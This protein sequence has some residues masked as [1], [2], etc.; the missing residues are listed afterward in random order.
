MPDTTAPD[1]TTPTRVQRLPA[2]A[3]NE[4]REMQEEIRKLQDT[5][6]LVEAENQRLRNVIAEHA[7]NGGPADTYLVNE[8]TAAE[9]PLGIGPEIRFNSVFSVHYEADVDL[10]IVETD[11]DMC[12]LPTD[13]GRIIEMGIRK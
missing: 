1:I 11:Q 10:L 2:W 4:R 3:R 13:F 9:L 8:D 6:K 12:I 7:E 5:L